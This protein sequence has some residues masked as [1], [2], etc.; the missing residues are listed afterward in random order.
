MLSGRTHCCRMHALRAKPQG[1]QA[2]M[3]ER[4]DHVSAAGTSLNCSSTAS[5]LC[6]PPHTA[7]MSS[8]AETTIGQ[9][10]VPDKI[11]TGEYPVSNWR[12]HR[13]QWLRHG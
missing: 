13:P 9:P 10:V 7:A 1:E 2:V 4:T 3:H 8:T 12:P 6:L 5:Q 11:P